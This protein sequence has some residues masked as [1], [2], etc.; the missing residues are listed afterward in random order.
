MNLKDLAGL[1]T[2][3]VLQP[4]GNFDVTVSGGYTGD[5]LSDV[6]ANAKEGNVWITCQ[7]HENIVAVARLKNLAA[8]ILVNGR[9]PGDAALQKAREERVVIFGTAE[10]EFAITGVLYNCFNK[11]KG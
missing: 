1:L 11:A 3:D 10:S 9:K 7:T 6:M 4:Q 8:I 5:L 2:L